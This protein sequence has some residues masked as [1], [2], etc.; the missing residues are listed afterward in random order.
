M[1]GGQTTLSLAANAEKTLYRDP[2]DHNSQHDR[3]KLTIIYAN[4]E[5]LSAHEAFLNKIQQESDSGCI[6]MKGQSD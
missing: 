5:E 1:T 2:S 4:S 6:W 3:P